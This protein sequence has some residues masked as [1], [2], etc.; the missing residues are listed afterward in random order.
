MGGLVS[1]D[2]AEGNTGFAGRQGRLAVG[3][4]K[5]RVRPRCGLIM[6]GTR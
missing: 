5:E 6:I 2:R 4:P 1:G 3:I